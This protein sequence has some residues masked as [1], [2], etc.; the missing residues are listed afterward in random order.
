[1]VKRH[2]KKRDAVFAVLAGTDTHPTAEWVYERLKPSFPDLSLAT[3]YRNI[4]EFREEG[5]VVSVGVVDGHEHFDADTSPHGHFICDVCGAIT[6]VALD[7]GAIP[8][9]S[10]VAAEG[11]VVRRAELTLRGTCKN[12]ARAHFGA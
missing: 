8:A 6:D 4:A 12:C 7:G 3:V 10:A 11:A 1:M 5:K 9:A 2:S